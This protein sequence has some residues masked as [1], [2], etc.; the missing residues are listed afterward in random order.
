M[1]LE[2]A[3]EKT[4]STR[5]TSDLYDFIDRVKKL[6]KTKQTDDEVLLSLEEYLMA[7]GITDILINYEEER[8]IYREQLFA[9]T[10]FRIQLTQYELEQKKMVVGH[11][12]LP[13]I[14][15]RI[16][17]QNIFLIDEEDN[18]I[19]LMSESI[20][21][22]QS[23]QFFSLLPPYGFEHYAM[24][25]EED[26]LQLYSYD[27][28]DW[29]KK[30]NFSPDDNILISPIDYQKNIFRLGYLDARTIATQKIATT[31]KDEDLSECLEDLLYMEDLMLPIDMQLF[32]AFADCE[33]HVLEQAGTPIG[34][35]ISN[36][37]TFSVYNN[38]NYAFLNTEENF[39]STLDDALDEA[40]FPDFDTMGEATDLDGIFH[41]IGNSYSSEFVRALMILQLQEGDKVDVEKIQTTLFK[42]GI[43][44]FYNEKQELNFNTAF[45]ELLKEIV[46]VWKT[47]RLALPHRKL[48]KKTTEFKTE[49]IEMLRSIDKKLENPEDF[50]YNLLFQLQPF[51][52]ITDQL[53][54]NLNEGDE[55]EFADP[56]NAKNMSKQ[57]DMMRKEFNIAKKHILDQ[58]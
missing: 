2:K 57:L 15:P 54:E 47:K 46:S 19:N 3:I 56:T 53:L 38:G 21:F 10:S 50:D 58:L 17:P 25:G 20:S 43:N 33:A 1:Q 27:L 22:E 37:P 28:S 44:P 6:V 42:K 49:I 41:E 26:R 13:F 7:K 23:G 5:N 30:Q 34:P 51:E 55:S 18:E 40:M 29:L 52:V 11:R 35:F 9:H 39:Q 12:F 14:H 31:R 32:Y 36:H 8:I 48:L 24:D 4:L 45:Q 16:H